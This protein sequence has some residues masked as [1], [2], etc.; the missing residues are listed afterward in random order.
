MTH[1]RRG[2]SWSRMRA[3]STSET[4]STAP[5]R[6]P[7]VTGSCG[8]VRRRSGA[9]RWYWWVQVPVPM[10]WLCGAGRLAVHLRLA[11]STPTSGYQSFVTDRSSP[12]MIKDFSHAHWR[13]AVTRRT[14]RVAIAAGRR[15]E[16][17]LTLLLSRSRHVP[18]FIRQG[19]PR[20][21]SRPG[22]LLRVPRCQCLA[23]NR[24]ARSAPSPDARPQL[25]PHGPTP[26]ASRGCLP[27]WTPT[28]FWLMNRRSPMLRLVRPC[29]HEQRGRSRVREARAP[30]VSFP[31][32]VEVGCTRRPP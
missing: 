22:D 32:I 12:G 30:N 14:P 7:V 31:T 10:G 1:G 8:E 17:A 19:V 16:V 9:G 3:D 18:G 4:G 27:T 5:E 21:R 20:S 28:V 29:A 2:L 26:P 24:A 6:S 13:I 11:L 25:P 23:P 15:H